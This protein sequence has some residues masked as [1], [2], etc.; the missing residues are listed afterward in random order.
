M[1]SFFLHVYRF[2]M[3]AVA[4]VQY[5]ILLYGTAFVWQIEKVV[6]V[7]KCDNSSVMLKPVFIYFCVYLRQP[8][9]FVQ[10]RY[11]VCVPLCTV[12][13]HCLKYCTELA[14][15]HTTNSFT[16]PL[17]KMQATKF[18]RHCHP[19]SPVINDVQEVIFM[20]PLGRIRSLQLFLYIFTGSVLK[21]AN[22]PVNIFRTEKIVQQFQIPS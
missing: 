15:Q 17:R 10:L 9:R 22:E 19:T 2:R 4:P 16:N 6:I 3:M 13:V 1:A 7:Y 12:V 20:A 11:H 5:C 8:V 18:F 14:S 21:L